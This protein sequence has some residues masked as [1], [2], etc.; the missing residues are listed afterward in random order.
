MVEQTNRM[1][2]ETDDFYLKSAAQMAALFPDQPKA[3]SNTRRIAEM[4]D[5]AF[6]LRD[7]AAARLPGP[8]GS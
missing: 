4:V 8:A 2:F 6:R 7:A 5:L 1:R 3:I